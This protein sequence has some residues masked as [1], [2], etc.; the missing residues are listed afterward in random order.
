MPH[1]L[2]SVDKDTS[3]KSSDCA[4]NLRGFTCILTMLPQ[5]SRSAHYC[6]QLRVLTIE[7]LLHGMSWP[8]APVH[9]CAIWDTREPSWANNQWNCD[10]VLAVNNM[11]I[12]SDFFLVVGG[13]KAWFVDARHNDE[14]T[15]PAYS[16]ACDYALALSRFQADEGLFLTSNT[17]LSLNRN[18]HKPGVWQITT[19][20]HH[21]GWPIV[22]IIDQIFGA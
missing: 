15:N 9:G 3:T 13:N 16:L 14:R 5:I 4:Q 7:Q 10:P 18:S 19:G 12:C 20:S 6:L 2:Q 22:L 21:H 11:N 1:L 17:V 8:V